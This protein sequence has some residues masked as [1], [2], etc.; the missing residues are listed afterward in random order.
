MQTFVSDG[1]RGFQFVPRVSSVN[2]LT[3]LPA[4]TTRGRGILS[5]R[6]VLHDVESYCC[7]SVSIAC[8]CCCRSSPAPSSLAPSPDLSASTPELHGVDRWRHSSQRKSCRRTSFGMPARV[9]RM[10][11]IAVQVRSHHPRTESRRQLAP[12]PARGTRARHGRGSIR[13]RHDL[14]AAG[15]GQCLVRA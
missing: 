1:T 6:G 14:A 2:L 15:R 4:Y 12:L 3:R 10:R 13:P 5:T 8:S 11:G 7:C 9:L